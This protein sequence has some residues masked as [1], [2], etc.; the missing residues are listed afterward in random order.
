MRAAGVD[1]T[2]DEVG[3]GRLPIVDRGKVVVGPI[4]GVVAG[5]IQCWIDLVRGQRNQRHRESVILRWVEVK[6]VT[7]ENILIDGIA[8]ETLAEVSRF[9]GEPD[10]AV[11]DRVNGDVATREVITRG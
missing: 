9:T 5:H 11:A 8:A 3:R 4:E 2:I 10:G 7:G 1:V 6:G